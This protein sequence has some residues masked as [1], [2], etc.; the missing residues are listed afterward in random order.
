V[1]GCTIEALLAGDIWSPHYSIEPWF[2]L[3][4]APYLG[5]AKRRG[6]AASAAPSLVQ[7]E[8]GPRALGCF[9]VYRIKHSRLHRNSLYRDSSVQ[10]LLLGTMSG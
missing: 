5:T 7:W 3:V 4:H 10:G 8:W 2:L 9:E 6:R 1:E